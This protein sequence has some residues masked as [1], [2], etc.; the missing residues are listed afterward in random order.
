MRFDD[1]TSRP[2]RQK[3]DKIAAIRSFSV[4]F[5][6]NCKVSYVPGEFMM[7]LMKCFMSSG[8]AVALFSICQKTGQMRPKDTSNVRC[9]IFLHIQPKLVLW[10]AARWTIQRI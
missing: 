1:K 8:A 9:K 4:Q 10:K 2:D 6:E 3:A 5:V 7:L